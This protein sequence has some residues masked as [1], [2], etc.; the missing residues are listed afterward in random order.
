MRVFV[1]GWDGLVG[2]ELRRALSGLRAVDGG[3][4]PD[5]D[6]RAPA[7]LRRRVLSFRPDWVV[8][9]AAW[10]AVDDCESDP[11]RALAANGLGA[12]HAASAAREAGARLLLVSTDYVFGGGAAGPVAEDARPAPLSVYGRSKRAGEALASSLLPPW[13]LLLVRGQ[14]LYGAGTKSF[15]DA[16][17]RAAGE[18]SAIPVVTDQVVSPTWARDFAGGLAALLG[19]GRTGTF[20][21]AAAGSCTWNEFARAVLETAGIEGVRVTETTAAALGR[22]A[23]RPAY[24]VFDTGKFERTTGMRPRHWRDQLRDYLRSTGRAA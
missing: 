23:P 20:H 14:S 22:P 7:A 5:L 19:Q 15:P 3:D 13:R 6:V 21:L 4:L 18:R 24:S 8:H 1:T 9:L 12:A 2:R 10:T 17:L 11:A 16:I